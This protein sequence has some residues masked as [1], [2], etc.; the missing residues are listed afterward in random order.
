[1]AAAQEYRGSSDFYVCHIKRLPDP[2]LGAIF[3][4]SKEVEKGNS[5]TVKQAAPVERVISHVA[6]RWRVVA[7]GRPELWSS[8]DA[9]VRPE[10]Q[11]ELLHWYLGHSEGRPLDV[12]I[13]LSRENWDP[14]G[15]LLLADVL[16][17]AN[18]LRCLSI[19]IDFPGADAAVRKA[20]RGLRAPLLEH[21]SFISLEQ[22]LSFRDRS[23]IILAADFGPVV[24]TGGLPRLA[25]L[26][27]QHLEHAI[28]PP[29]TRVT[30]F[31]L[32][33]YH[34]PPMASSRFVE[35]LREMPALENLSLY[36]DMVAVW[37]AAGRIPLPRL[38]SLRS[39]SNEQVGH[40]LLAL[41][42]PAL[43]SLVLKDVRRSHI[44]A[45]LGHG[46]GL[47][48]PALRTLTLDGS[49]VAP[50][51]A[52][53]FCE[54]ASVEELRFVNCDADDALELL[55]RLGGD[56]LLPELRK[57]MVHQ[58]GDIAS[59][60]GVWARGLAVQVHC[61]IPWMQPGVERWARLP[62]WPVELNRA[63]A[64]DLFMQLRPRRTG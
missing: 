24:F 17:E 47:R 63:D 49:I 14:E 41:D 22:P 29:L 48:F 50:T 26:R 33:E 5:K 25:V 16:A 42:T 18:R 4:L 39:A 32:E 52:A 23:D 43:E 56:A 13:T 31:H 2:V 62:P 11:R 36:G 20:C 40:M 30:T 6:V 28:Y 35:F 59:L 58:V 7:L 51:L 3:A 8:I 38:R 15:Q 57:V 64:D 53:L 45:A 44:Q 12:H 54:L 21:L 9:R 61:D 10:Y 46:D 27:L 37:P 19:R 55:A 34:C 60:N 1:M